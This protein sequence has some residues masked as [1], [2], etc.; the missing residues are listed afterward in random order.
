ME[1]NDNPTGFA[2]FM[3]EKW[4]KLRSASTGADVS[5]EPIG[6]A[7]AAMFSCATK[8]REVCG[9]EFYDEKLGY[10]RFTVPN[11]D[12]ARVLA[13]ASGALSIALMDSAYYPKE[14]ATR[15]VC[16]Y[17]VR[18]RASPADLIPTPTRTTRFDGTKTNAANT[19][20]PGTG[21]RVIRDR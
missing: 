14:K 9:A 8:L 5:L 21:K 17:I 7:R 19:P 6:D 4:Q 16:I 12:L 18:H 13:V 20:K 15:I 2:A 1:P 3:R 11:Q 10:P